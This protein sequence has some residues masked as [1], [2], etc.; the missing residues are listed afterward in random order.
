MGRKT[1][2]D[3]LFRPV[4]DEIAFK[5]FDGYPYIVPTAQGTNR[6]TNRLRNEKQALASM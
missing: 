3:A 2:K 1:G 4:R 5:T 6:N